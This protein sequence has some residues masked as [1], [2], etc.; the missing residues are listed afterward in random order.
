M[1][2]LSEAGEASILTPSPGCS[3]RTATSMWD[4]RRT[5]PQTWT[6]SGNSWRDPKTFAP[7]RRSTPQAAIAAAMAAIDRDRDD[8]RRRGIHLTS[9]GPDEYRNRLNVGVLDLTPGVAQYVRS[10]YGGAM[11]NVTQGEYVCPCLI[12]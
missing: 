2:R 9:Y 3:W 12:P 8:L 7:L 1:S 4:W 11:V 10:Q 6:T 5:R